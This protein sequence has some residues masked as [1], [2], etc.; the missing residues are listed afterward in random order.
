MD[1]TVEPEAT[2]GDACA[3]SEALPALRR[4][5]LLISAWGSRRSSTEVELFIEID[6][7]LQET[8]KRLTVMVGL[9]VTTVTPRRKIHRSICVELRHAEYWANVENLYLACHIL[10]HYVK[11]AQNYSAAFAARV[12]MIAMFGS[13]SGGRLCR[14]WRYSVLL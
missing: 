8:L 11:L 4:C 3:G 7:F 1:L 9:A 5:G 14:C 13:N 12:S 10:D 2:A 6:L